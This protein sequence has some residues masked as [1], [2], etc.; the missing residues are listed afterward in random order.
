MTDQPDKAQLDDLN[1]T[2]AFLN[3]L[4]SAYQGAYVY[5]NVYG[6]LSGSPDREEKMQKTAQVLDKIGG[7]QN[8]FRNHQPLMH[9]RFLQEGLKDDPARAWRL[10]EV[11]QERL[12][13]IA[14][15]S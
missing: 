13:S 6:Q 1:L 5:E 15:F 2:H 11:A 14:E 3:S 7:W 10:L 12:E 9:H 4:I 8:D